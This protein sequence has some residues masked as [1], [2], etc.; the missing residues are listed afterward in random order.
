MVRRVNE[1]REDQSGGPQRPVELLTIAPGPAGAATLLGSLADAIAGVGPALALAPA[2]D[3]EYARRMRSAVVGASGT[4]THQVDADIA[5]VVST[6]GS[7]GQPRGVLLPAAAL[8]ASAHAAHELMGGP[9]SWLLAV[10]VTSVAGVQVLVRS[11]IAQTEPVVLSS[12]GG[13]ASFDPTEFARKA[14][15]LDPSL[16][17]Y[18]S[19]VPTQLARILDDHEALSALQGFDAVLIG[20]ARLAPPMAE[21]LDAAY[22]RWFSTYGMTETSGGLFYNGEPLSGATVELRD[23]DEHGTGRIVVRGPMLAR[24][25]FDDPDAS[26]DAFVD[27]YVTS[28][29]GRLVDG[30]LEVIGRIDDVVQV[31]GVNVALSAVE[32]ILKRHCADAVVL[33]EPDNTWGSYVSAFVAG[34]H[35]SG[36]E[37]LHEIE[38]TL[39]KAARPRQVVTVA[40]I[41]Y[42]PNGKPDREALRALRGER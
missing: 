15:T 4:G 1:H 41:P 24:G 21:R 2:G 29:L 17:A 37:F 27:G 14:W 39:G 38:L 25:Y 16:P 19:L 18:C 3:D 7:L 20:G 12:I 6:S 23:I 32:D 35:Q 26:K 31:G 11:L 5:L 22:V 30:R 10:P 34:A 28:D 13:A 8:L 9:G 33:A 42:S 40:E 36:D